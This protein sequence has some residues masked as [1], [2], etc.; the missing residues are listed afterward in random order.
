MLGAMGRSQ[1]LG[2]LPLR[3]PALPSLQKSRDMPHRLPVKTVI[4]MM[5]PVLLH[6]PWMQRQRLLGAVPSPRSRWPNHPRGLRFM[7]AERPR[8]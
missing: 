2:K 8:R 7:L 4:P 6:R 1:S 3:S 5:S